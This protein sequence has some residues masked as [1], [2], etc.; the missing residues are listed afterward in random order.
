MKGA[1]PQAVVGELGQLVRHEMIEPKGVLGQRESL[2]RPMSRVQHDGR[3]RLVD[4]ATLDP[5]QPILDVVDAPNAMPAGEV[6]EALNQLDRR[7]PFAV[8]RNGY[9]ALE[10]DDDLH[11][12]RRFR[13]VD[14]PRVDI[15]RRRDPW[16]FE[17]AGLDRTAPQ[18]DVD[19]VRG[20]LRD[21]DLDA[22]GGGVVDLLIARQAHPDAHRRDH[23]EARV[24]RVDGDVEADLL[25]ADAEFLGDAAVDAV[26][27]TT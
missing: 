3:G 11:R 13:G 14:G 21:R 12:L 20:L 10:L 5:H 27:K 8:E 16:I 26:H 15:G 19:R 9:P 2:E 24:E 23:L 18:V 4:L 6:A 1:E 22:A 17:D 25:W 7:E